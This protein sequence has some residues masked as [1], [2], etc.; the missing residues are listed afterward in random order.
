MSA[1]RIEIAWVDDDGAVVVRAL[2]L[3]AGAT[4]AD[5]LDALG[6]TVAARLRARVGSNELAVAVYGKPR[7]LDAVLNDGDRV[8]LVGALV[9]DPRTAR[10]M[11]VRQRRAEGGDPRWTRR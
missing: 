8:E 1:L 6:D 4:P 11:R 2:E 7:A 9:I 10:R 5:A 3:P